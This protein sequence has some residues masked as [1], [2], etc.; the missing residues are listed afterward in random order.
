ME[1]EKEKPSRYD[2]YSK[3]FRAGRKG[4]PCRPTSLEYVSGYEHGLKAGQ[5]GKFP[6]HGGGQRNRDQD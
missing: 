3:G 5:I 2:D 4:K 1:K 6:P